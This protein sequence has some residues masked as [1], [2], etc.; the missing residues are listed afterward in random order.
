MVR[1]SEKM[2]DIAIAEKVDIAIMMDTSAACGSQVIYNG[3]RFDS[4]KKYQIGMGVCAAQLKRNGVLVIS[5]RDFASL[6]VLFSKIDEKYQIDKQKIDHHE[7]DW[8]KSY[9]RK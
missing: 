5:Q 6:E 4:N 8:Y 9:F 3:N 7:T 1:A 2:L